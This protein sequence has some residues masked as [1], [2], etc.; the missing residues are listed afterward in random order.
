VAPTEK[1]FQ[2]AG[3]EL[4][5]AGLHPGILLVDDIDAPTPAHHTAVLV[6]RL[7]RPQAIANSHDPGALLRRKMEPG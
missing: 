7:G 2:K 6:A 3:D 5:L 1:G 4:T